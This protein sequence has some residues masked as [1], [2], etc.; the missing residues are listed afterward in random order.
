MD[1]GLL[2]GSELEFGGG[3]CTV[4]DEDGDAYWTWFEVGKSGTFD[5]KVMGGTG[6][7]AGSSGSGVTTATKFHVD[8][9]ATFRIEGRSKS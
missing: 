2:P 8:G 4:L 5:W 6:K 3:Y 9:T 7:Y 1:V